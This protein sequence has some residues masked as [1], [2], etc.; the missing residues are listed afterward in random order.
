[1]ARLK[2]SKLPNRTPVRLAISV[3]PELHTKLERY[4]ECYRDSYGE[5]ERIV[6]LIPFML[7]AFLAS[8]K[9]FAK[10]RKAGAHNTPT[11]G[12]E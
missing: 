8:D 3:S 1:M 12:E 6:E 5:N 11:E 7:E 4:A 10:S 9:E 2:L